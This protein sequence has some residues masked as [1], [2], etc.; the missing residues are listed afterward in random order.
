MLGSS[1]FL[2][3]CTYCPCVWFSLTGQ[4]LS[5][6]RRVGF[7][8]QFCSILCSA[9]VGFCVCVCVWNLSL[10]SFIFPTCKKLEC[11]FPFL[12]PG[13]S[14]DEH[15]TA[16]EAEKS[17]VLCKHCSETAETLITTILIRNPKHGIMHQDSVKKTNPIPAKILSLSRF[18]K[19]ALIS[20][21]LSLNVYHTCDLDL[22][23]LSA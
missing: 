7:L 6:R 4:K 17:F 16:W 20:C 15:W 10:L 18:F 22:R 14:W 11:C 9:T 8:E 19:A 2:H 1:H 5:C 23:A 12:L 3:R 21:G 13:S